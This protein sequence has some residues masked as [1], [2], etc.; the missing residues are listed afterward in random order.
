MCSTVIV[1]ILYEH[2]IL[3]ICVGEEHGLRIYDAGENIQNQENE[4]AYI[5][6]K[7]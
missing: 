1:L 5:M 4:G 2:G 6:R 3:F 7:V